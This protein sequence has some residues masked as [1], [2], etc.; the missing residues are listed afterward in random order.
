MHKLEE[1]L[2]TSQPLV[3]K[4]ELAVAIGLNEAIALQQLQYW[5]IIKKKSG[6][7]RAK[8]DGYY[9][10]WNSIESW[11]EQFPFWSKRTIKRTF[12]SLEKQ[13][14]I[15]VKKLSLDKTDRTNYY[16]IK[17]ECLDHG[18]KMTQ[19]E[20]KGQNDPI[21]LGQNGTMPL[22]QNGTMDGDKMTQSNLTETTHKTTTE[23]PQISVSEKFEQTPLT[24]IQ[25]QALEVVEKLENNLLSEVPKFKPLTE[26][27][28]KKWMKDIDLAIRKDN[29]TKEE[30]LGVVDWIYT[31]PK[32]S[33]WIP[34]IMSGAKLRK[35]L[36]KL[37]YDSKIPKPRKD[38]KEM[39]FEA[40]GIGNV[41]LKA[42]NS[43]IDRTISVCLNGEHPF[44]EY[45]NYNTGDKLQG[46]FLKK[47]EKYVAE[48]IDSIIKGDK[49]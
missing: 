33:F 5:L 17:Y 29:I 27:Q 21:P 35:Q 19:W 28:K 30:I 41:F 47:V 18:D 44:L 13:G 43:R 24:E 11:S 7:P 25:E 37:L 8:I 4:P 32:G 14:L 16:T 12:A 23:T 49:Q 31:N 15:L 48:H 45:T 1:L 39:L 46:E 40:Y 3:L 20:N 26:A 42:I 38:I 36:P 22:G 9:W 34:N 2:L 6:D 10:V